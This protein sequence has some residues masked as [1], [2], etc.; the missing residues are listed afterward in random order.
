MLEGQSLS[1]DTLLDESHLADCES[2]IGRPPHF[3]TPEHAR[4]DDLLK[5][6]AEAFELVTPSGNSPH[7]LAI[8]AT[9]DQFL[10][11]IRERNDMLL[12]GFEIIGMPLVKLY[13]DDLIA[14]NQESPVTRGHD[15]VR[16]IAAAQCLLHTTKGIL[17]TPPGFCFTFIRS[18]S[19]QDN[20]SLYLP[21][22]GKVQ[23]PKE[24]FPHHGIRVISMSSSDS[25]SEAE[26]S[27]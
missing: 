26:I 18:E 20:L 9:I 22:Y 17:Q 27:V 13:S 14:E 2:R 15:H 24:N 4:I 23:V 7:D 10:Q 8:L 6:V 5:K 19:D 16:V 12:E 25:D 21:G 11:E 1:Y 3:Y